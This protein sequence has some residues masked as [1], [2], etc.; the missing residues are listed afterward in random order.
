M[1]RKI[2]K[3][4]GPNAGT[5]VEVPEQSIAEAMPHG[6]VTGNDSEEKQLAQ[7]AAPSDSDT[8]SNAGKQSQSTDHQNSY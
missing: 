2:T 7:E 1:S 5:T 4:S 8:S 6:S 3:L